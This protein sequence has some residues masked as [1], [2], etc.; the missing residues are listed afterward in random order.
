MC[1]VCSWLNNLASIFQEFGLV[2]ASQFKPD[3]IPALR[4]ISSYVA[5]GGWEE[6]S[7]NVL[8]KKVAHP[9]LG[10]LGSGQD[11]RRRLNE[12]RNETQTGAAIEQL[13]Y[14]TIGKRPI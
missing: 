5:I 8:D 7:H 12:V 1:R 14:V 10:I 3:P 11:L 6:F 4:P 2:D 9:L 13:H